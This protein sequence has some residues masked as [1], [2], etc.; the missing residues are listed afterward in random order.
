MPVDFLSDEQL[1]HYGRFSCVPSD[2]QL[3]RYFYLDD[4]DSTLIKKRRGDHNPL[5]NPYEQKM[6]VV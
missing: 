6:L 2:E 4:T 1:K 5:R 3:S